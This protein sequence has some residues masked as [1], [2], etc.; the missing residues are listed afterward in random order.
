M[1]RVKEN[2][3][4][5]AAGRH[6]NPFA[7]LGPHTDKKVAQVRTFQPQASSVSLVDA[8][9]ILIAKMRKVHK[10]GGFSAKL[11][12]PGQPYRLRLTFPDGSSAE[13]EDSY[14]FASA[15][16]ECDGETFPDKPK[17]SLS[18]IGSS[19]RGT[20]PLSRGNGNSA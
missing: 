16:T 12:E 17:A 2:W 6:V 19:K 3:D 7:F 13:T 14:R 8:D 11:K 10:E 18:L 5:I 1:Q 4:A 9:G 15:M 20:R